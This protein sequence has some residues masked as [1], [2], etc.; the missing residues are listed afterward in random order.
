MHRV[1]WTALVLGAC[2]GAHADQLASY[3]V[4]ASDIALMTEPCGA[5]NGKILRARRRAHGSAVDGCWAVNGRGNPVVMWGDGE[6]QELNESRV[7][8]APKYAAMLGDGAPHGAA[9][10]QDTPAPAF[11]RPAWC[12]D[13]RQAHERLICRD[14]ALSAADLSLAPLWRSYRA[15]LKLNDIQQG[16]QKSDYFRRLK[17]CGAQKECIAREQAAQM[18]LYRQALQR[19]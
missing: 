10:T 1:L 8:L 5:E 3:R 13:A 6:V 2:A 11:A 19:Q 9:P 15:A 17:A 4:G 7:R 12:M 16:R 14:A 18:R